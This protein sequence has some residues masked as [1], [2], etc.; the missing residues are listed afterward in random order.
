MLQPIIEKQTTINEFTSGATVGII[1]PLIVDNQMFQPRIIPRMDRMIDP[2]VKIDWKI[3]DG[4]WV[5]SQMARDN[6]LLS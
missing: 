1:F 4:Q 3:E 5:G 6:F 2:T